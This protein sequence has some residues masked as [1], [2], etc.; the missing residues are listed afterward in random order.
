MNIMLVSVTERTFEVGLAK[1]AWRDSEADPAPV[2]DRIRCVVHR[3]RRLG[4]L[5]AISRRSYVGMA[6]RITMTI[7]LFYI[8]VSIAVSSI[9]GSSPDSTQRGKLRAR[10]DR[11]VDA[12]LVDRESGIV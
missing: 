8:F 1:S 6:L 9:I 10:S 4:L 12:E 7:E 5:L 2:P 11:S 3:R